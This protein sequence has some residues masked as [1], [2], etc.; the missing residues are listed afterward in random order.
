M[1]LYYAFLSSKDIPLF[2]LVLGFV[3]LLEQMPDRN[4]VTDRFT[5]ANSFRGLGSRS[6]SS[7]ALGL[8]D[9]KDQ[10]GEYIV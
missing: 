6:A 1:L 5:L 7:S 3:L 4:N 10:Q 8:S 9:Q 2:L